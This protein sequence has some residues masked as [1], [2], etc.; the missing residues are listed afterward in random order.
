MSNFFL[1]LMSSLYL[2]AGVNHFV[3]PKF[4]LKIIPQ[5]LPYHSFINYGSGVLEI[6][7]ALML[8]PAST[9]VLGAWLII[10]LLIAIF[11]ANIKMCVDFYHKSHPQFWITLV[12]LPLQFVL[13]W[14]A[15]IYTK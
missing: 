1:Y 7:F 14:W 13:I 3:N 8:I 11:P 6:V 10:A 15:W 2:L 4:Y 12:R 9:R 5:W